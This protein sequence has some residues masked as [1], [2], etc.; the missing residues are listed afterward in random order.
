MFSCWLWELHL[1]VILG[2]PCPKVKSQNLCI[3]T[4]HLKHFNFF[5]Y[6]ICSFPWTKYSVFSVFL[7]YTGFA[8]SPLRALERYDIEVNFING[9]HCLSFIFHASSRLSVIM[10]KPQSLCGFH[11]EPQQGPFF[12]L[13]RKPC[14]LSRKM[15]PF[16]AKLSEKHPFLSHPSLHERNVHWEKVPYIKMIRNQTVIVNFCLYYF[17][18]HLQRL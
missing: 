14:L 4:A 1:Y 18:E 7:L 13:L 12:F 6:F 3:F 8:W 15:P 17:T 2:L 10:P 16:Q 9:I 11:P 5:G